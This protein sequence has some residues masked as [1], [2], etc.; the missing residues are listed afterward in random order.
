MNSSAT[1]GSFLNTPPAVDPAA[2]ERD[3]YAIVRGFWG[4]GG[5]LDALQA[6]LDELGKL[7]VGP[8]FSSTRY[9]DCCELLTPQRQSLLYDRLKYLPALSRMSGSEAVREL[10]IALGLGLPSL[11]GC[12]NMRL[13]K[14]GDARHLFEWHQDTLYLLGSTNAV[15]LWIPLQ[16]VDLAHGTIEVIPGSHAQGI[17]PFRKVSDKAVAPG[18]PFLQRDLS[19]AIEVTQT[20]LAIEAKRGDVVV[21]RQMLLHRSTPNHS[22]QIR[23]TAQLRVTDVAEAEHRRQRCPSGDRSNIFHVDYPGFRPVESRL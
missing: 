20:P 19:L 16:D 3:G 23:W 7:I 6:Q 11:M 18:V 21:F 4:A 1:L 22:T 10:C 15:T 17:L 2:F 14:P 12:C 13:D 5:E 9:R 8:A